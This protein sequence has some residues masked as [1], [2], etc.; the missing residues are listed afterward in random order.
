MKE[1]RDP[2]DEGRRWAIETFGE[3][4]V[5]IRAR[6]AELV[7]EE[8]AALMDAQEASGHRS[9][10]VYGQFWHGILERFEE[11]DNLPHATLIRPG[12]A[13]YRIP[14]ING[15]ALFAWRW[16]R[17]RG[18]ELASV[19]FVTSEARSAMFEL[20]SVPTQGKFELGMP[21]T[22][23]SDEEKELAETVEAAMADSLVTAN[24]VVV[25]A[26]SSS[27][28]GLHEMRWGEATV[29]DDGYLRWG[30]AEDLRDVPAPGPVGVADG[31]KSFT[32]GEPPAKKLRLQSE[33]DGDSGIPA[34]DDD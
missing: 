2:V 11:F 28:M 17:A 30:F 13:P 4:G 20:D 14:V 3:F 32:S 5:H 23:L 27:P 8:H 25:V 29:T 26:I 1:G 22:G 12:R 10:G 9:Q 19:P 31:G 6:A 34:S 7:R 24:K 33:P 16:S 18:V 21:D 15:V